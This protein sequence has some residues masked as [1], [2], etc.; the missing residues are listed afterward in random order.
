[1]GGSVA[2]EARADEVWSANMARTANTVTD[3]LVEPTPV[4]DR[5]D[6]DYQGWMKAKLGEA[7]TESYQDALGWASIETGIT[8]DEFPDACPYAWDDIL[9][10]PF[11]VDDGMRKPL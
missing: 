4:R 3:D 11:Q 1:M 10:R 7:L 8:D 9:D 2:F 6:A 5:Y